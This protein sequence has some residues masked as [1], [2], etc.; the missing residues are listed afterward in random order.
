MS[1]W[2]NTILKVMLIIG[3]KKKVEK[4]I[5]DHNDN[6][7]YDDWDNDQLDIIIVKEKWKWQSPSKNM[8]NK[9]EPKR[10]GV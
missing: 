9:Q 10:Q 3:R 5:N 2:Q 6:V 4:I 8:T 7:D 1:L